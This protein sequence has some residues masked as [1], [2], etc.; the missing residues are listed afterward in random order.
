MDI[1]R[2]CILFGRT[3][4]ASLAQRQ[5]RRLPARFT[6]LP[7]QE[8]GR[9]SKRYAHSGTTRRR[10]VEHQHMLLTSLGAHHCEL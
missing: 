10:N 4:L 8:R 9:K 7:L 2:P 3:Y 1:P 5:L 6:G